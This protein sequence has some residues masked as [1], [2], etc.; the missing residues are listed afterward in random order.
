ML[1]VRSA[2][3]TNV[4]YE[5]DG[6]SLSEAPGFTLTQIAGED[7]ILKK[8]MGKLPTKIGTVLEHESRSLFRIGPK[9]IWV[10]GKELSPADGVYLTPLSSGR[11]RIA[12]EGSRARDALSA[13]AAI[14]FDLGQF[15]PG[16]FVMTGIHH[17]PVTIHCIGESSFHIYALR[18]FSLNFWDW[19]CDLSEGLPYA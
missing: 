12:L 13:C 9:Q 7:K 17:T 1:E 11:T 18:T 5:R 3:G 6:I 19:L 4:K 14:D 16:H 10:L 8:I 15:K 2:L